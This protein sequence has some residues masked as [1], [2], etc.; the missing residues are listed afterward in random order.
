MLKNVATGL[1][2]Q[3]HEYEVSCNVK[4]T[5]ISVKNIVLTKNQFDI[6]S[7]NFLSSIWKNNVLVIYIS[8]WKPR[9]N[10]LLS[11]LFIYK[12]VSERLNQTNFSYRSY[13]SIYVLRWDVS[14]S[15]K[16]PF[17]KIKKQLIL[18]SLTSVT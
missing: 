12:I 4:N 10:S 3:Q 16:K 6:F 8:Y 14:K 2:A 9:L 11:K 7:M 1:N 13:F 5:Y 15:I 18:I 17:I